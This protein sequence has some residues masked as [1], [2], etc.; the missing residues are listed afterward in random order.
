M[1]PEYKIIRCV[2]LCGTHLFE[3]HDRAIACYREDMAAGFFAVNEKGEKNVF[4]C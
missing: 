3:N 4:T 2:P 1:Y